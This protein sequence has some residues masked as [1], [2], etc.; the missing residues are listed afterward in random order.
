M[1][2]LMPAD[3]KNKKNKETRVLSF[4]SRNRLMYLFYPRDTFRNQ[5]RNLIYNPYH[6][7]HRYILATYYYYFSPVIGL[8]DITVTG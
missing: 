3:F 5:I 4:E 8:Y 7:M 1:D 2:S 6:F